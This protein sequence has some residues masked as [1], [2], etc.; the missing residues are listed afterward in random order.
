MPHSVAPLPR[1]AVILPDTLACMG[2]KQLLLSIM[3]RVEVCL[4]GSLNELLNAG[5]ML[6]SLFHLV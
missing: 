6:Y 3:P 5:R 2:M 1:M 4:Y